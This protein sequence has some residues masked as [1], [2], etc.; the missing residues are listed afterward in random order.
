VVPPSYES[1]IDRWR[2]KLREASFRV[3]DDWYELRPAVAPTL[4][5]PPGIPVD[6]LKAARP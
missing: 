6:V 1:A 5:P 4:P 3:L 2:R